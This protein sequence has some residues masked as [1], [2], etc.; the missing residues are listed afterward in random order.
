MVAVAGPRT[1]NIVHL[2]GRDRDHYRMAGALL[3]IVEG[4]LVG[5][6]R[7]C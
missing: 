7:W 2:G 4:G 3:G 1:V 6:Q 5:G